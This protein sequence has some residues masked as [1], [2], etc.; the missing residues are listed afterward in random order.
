MSNLKRITGLGTACIASFAFGLAEGI[1]TA[2]GFPITDTHLD[3]A[4]MTGFPFLG[5][6]TGALTFPNPSDTER[7]MER[8]H[9][10][11]TG[12]EYALISGERAVGAGLGF[13]GSAVSLGLGYALGYAGSHILNR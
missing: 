13:I 3:D 9:Q 2:R 8:Y 7:E 12:M 1:S 11:P 5:A 4:L 10:R 6:I